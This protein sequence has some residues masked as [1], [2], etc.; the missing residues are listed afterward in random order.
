MMLVV[1]LVL[2]SV[3]SSFCEECR[4][5]LS[6]LPRCPSVLLRLLMGTQACHLFPFHHWDRLSG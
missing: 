5:V 1:A 6:P 2:F 3:S 4:H